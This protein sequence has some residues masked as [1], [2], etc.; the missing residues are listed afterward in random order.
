[1]W[2][3]HN[4]LSIFMVVNIKALRWSCCS[5]ISKCQSSISLYYQSPIFQYQKRLNIYIY[6]YILYIIL[7]I[8]Y[9]IYN[10]YNFILLLLLL[11]LSL[12]ILLLLLIL[13][14]LL[15]FLLLL[16]F[17]LSSIFFVNVWI[18][19]YPLFLCHRLKLVSSIFYQIFISLPNDSLSKTMKNVFYFI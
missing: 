14:L 15:L 2:R 19:L 10:I 11:L 7:Y 8:I 16:S 6:I 13:I 12:L 4:A 1:M 5:F 18:V 17:A 9:I 3:V